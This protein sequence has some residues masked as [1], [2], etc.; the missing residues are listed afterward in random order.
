MS[1]PTGLM[2][3]EPSLAISAREHATDSA[4]LIRWY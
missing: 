2:T 4:A 3:R 1:S